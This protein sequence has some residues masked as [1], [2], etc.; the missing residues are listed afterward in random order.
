M[1]PSKNKPTEP[2]KLTYDEILNILQKHYPR[3]ND[4]ARQHE[5]IMIPGIGIMD[6]V[7]SP[8]PMYNAY[9]YVIRYFIDHDVYMKVKGYNS[10]YTGFSVSDWSDCEQVFPKEKKVLYFEGIDDDY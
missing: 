5:D 9:H 8:S 7:R 6:E 3:V 2:I 10:S 1:K 4:F